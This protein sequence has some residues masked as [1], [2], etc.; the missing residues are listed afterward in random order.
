MPIANHFE[1]NSDL[2]KRSGWRTSTRGASF[3]PRNL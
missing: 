3:A 2:P 1:A